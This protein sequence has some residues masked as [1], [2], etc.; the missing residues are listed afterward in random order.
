M[1]ALRVVRAH[2]FVVL[3]RVADEIW[4]AGAGGS[5]F[6]Q[7]GQWPGW[8]KRAKALRDSTFE[9]FVYLN[10]SPCRRQYYLQKA[11]EGWMV[12]FTLLL[13]NY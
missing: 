13:S 4:E 3:L 7:E 10:L 8:L 6:C 11:S 2:G 5:A 9:S 1:P 12:M